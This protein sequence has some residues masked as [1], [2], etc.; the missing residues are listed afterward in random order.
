[1]AES[2]DMYTL[3]VLSPAAEQ[4]LRE[5]GQSLPPVPGALEAG[6]T[7]EAFSKRQ[8]EIQQY[9]SIVDRWNTELQELL[10]QAKAIVVVPPYA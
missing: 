7:M 1:M 4:S 8:A 2:G 5:S 9:N 10:I 3:H 6:L